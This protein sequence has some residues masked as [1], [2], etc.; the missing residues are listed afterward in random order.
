[1]SKQENIYL[2]RNNNSG[3]RKELPAFSSQDRVLVMGSRMSGVEDMAT[4]LKDFL[5]EKGLSHLDVVYIRNVDRIRNMFLYNTLE[6]KDDQEII[7]P[8]GA[9]LLPEMRQ[10]DQYAGMS[11]DVY[12]SG[13]AEYV[14]GLCNE[15]H[16]PLVLIKPDGSVDQVVAGLKQILSSNK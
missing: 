9:I 16:V 6:P 13:V 3:D 14:S 8:K 1:M 15:Y 10:Y 5:E 2:Y 11:I 7:P 4:G 12:K